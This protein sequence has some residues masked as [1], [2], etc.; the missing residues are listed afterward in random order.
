METRTL[1]NSD[2]PICDAEMGT[3]RAYSQKK[4]LPIAFDDL[5]EIDLKK[6]KV[7]EDEAARFLHVMHQG[8]LYVGTRAFLILWEQMPKYRLL[9]KIGS[10]PGIYYLAD[11]IYVNVV[12]KIIYNRHLK[13]KSG[14]LVHRT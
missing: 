8:H 13:R 14:G 1:Y 2:C 4:G 9:A 3:Y 10:L 11:I 5:N 12:S 6:W 7:T